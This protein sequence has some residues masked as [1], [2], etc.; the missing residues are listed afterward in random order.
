MKKLL[1]AA[2]LVASLGSSAFALDVNK[3]N[4]KVQAAFSE[5][6]KGATDVVWRIT[7]NYTQVR[8]TIAD[9]QL[10]AYFSE[11]GEM[12]GLSR[13]VEFKVLP[14]NAIQKIKQKY[15]DYTVTES[16]EFTNEGEKG[17]YVALEKGNSKKVLSVSIY[18]TVS[19]F[20]VLSK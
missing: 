14:I 17:Y 20:K 13:K 11:E 15:S 9:E 6:F 3:V 1:I 12:F 7:D 5:N 18:G 4:Y 19:V 2:L 8:F 10:E 16:I